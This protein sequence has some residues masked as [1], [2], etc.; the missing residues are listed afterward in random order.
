MIKTL[1]GLPRVDEQVI[2]KYYTFKGSEF[3]T[4]TGSLIGDS[5][6]SITEYCLTK[7]YKDIFDEENVAV[8][9][10]IRIDKE[11]SLEY[12]KRL[13]YDNSS[14]NAYTNNIY[15]N[16]RHYLNNARITTSITKSSST[17]PS[18]VTT[19]TENLYYITDGEVTRLGGD[20][21]L[22]DVPAYILALSEAI[23]SSTEIALVVEY[24]Y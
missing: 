6:T 4:E 11:K 8:I 19:P 14:S 21:A 22:D 3:T 20:Y 24:V 13:Q 9:R 16:T 2:T 15:E 5:N 17:T 23:P 10:E 12:A 7:T 18:T 1:N